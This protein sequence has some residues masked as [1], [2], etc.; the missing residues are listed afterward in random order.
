MNDTFPST[1]AFL[2]IF[3]EEKTKEQTIVVWKITLFHLKHLLVS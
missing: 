1:F 3:E 2:V